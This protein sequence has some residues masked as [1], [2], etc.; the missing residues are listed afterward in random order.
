MWFVKIQGADPQTG[1]KIDEYNCAM[2]WQ[3]ILMVENSGQLR[4]V[5]VSVQSLRNE[6]IK[7]QDVALGLVANAKVIRN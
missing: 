2:S 6:T 4:G 7:R 3:P 5:A 1:D